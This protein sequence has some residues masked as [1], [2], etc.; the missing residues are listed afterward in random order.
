MS[1]QSRAAA[2]RSARAAR[3]A[4]QT[5]SPCV[6]HV[7]ERAQ[8][9]LADAVQRGGLGALLET[10]AGAAVSAGELLAPAWRARKVVLLGDTCN[11]QAIA[12]ARRACR[13]GV[14]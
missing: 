3:A 1:A 11:S 14:G 8:A 7:L 13:P 4:A 5:R 12:G 6:Q 2:R 9:A 10:P